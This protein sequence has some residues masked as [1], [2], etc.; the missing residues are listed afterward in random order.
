[1][2]YGYLNRFAGAAGSRRGWLW[3]H[4][5]CAGEFAVVNDFLL[6]E[7]D[8]D[9]LKLAHFVR[10]VEDNLIGMNLRFGD[11]TIVQIANE[12]VLANAVGFVDVKN[13]F[14]DLQRVIVAF[15]QFQL[16]G[17]DMLGVIED[18]LE[19]IEIHKRPFDFVEPHFFDFRT[20]GD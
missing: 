2:S 14:I 13:Q 17:T 3:W 11:K 5:V 9:A 8:T 7:L 6:F 16:P 20:A 12:F 4:P 19:L 10:V 1:P 15:S 18:V